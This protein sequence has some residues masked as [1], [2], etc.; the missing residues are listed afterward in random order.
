MKIARRKIKWL[1]R[2]M[3]VAA[4]FTQ[5]I[6]AAHACVASAS[7]AV[8]TVSVQSGDAAMPCHEAEQHN[9]N[10]CVMHCTQAD[11][12]NLEQQHIA[13]ISFDEAVLQIALPQMQHKVVTV[14]PATFALNSGPPLSILF[15]T[16]LI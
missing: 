3:L 9:A 10:A 5:G 15:C 6:L 2:L 16:F 1:T 8:H 13:A 14:Y 11:Q 7:S 12:V 4:L